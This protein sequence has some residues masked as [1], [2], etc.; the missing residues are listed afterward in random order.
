MFDKVIV[1]YDGSKSAEDALALAARNPV[2]V[3][4]VDVEE[5]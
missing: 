2:S 1:G 5:S 4:T 3:R